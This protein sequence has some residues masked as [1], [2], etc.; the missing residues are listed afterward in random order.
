MMTRYSVSLARIADEL[1]M[2]VVASSGDLARREVTSS[3]LHRP[4]L[5]LTGYTSHF[6]PE[7]LQVI[8]W[9]ETAYLSELDPET[10]DERLERF[11]SLNVPG[12]VVTRGLHVM[13]D[14]VAAADRH[15]T[16]VLA[17]NRLTSETVALLNRFLVRELAPR[18]MVM[19][20]FVDVYGEGVLLLGHRGMARG[21]TALELV[22]RGHRLIAAQSVELRRLSD[23]EL[24]GIAPAGEGHLLELGGI[25]KI[26]V[27]ALYGLQAVKSEAPVSFV[28][29]LEPRVP[30]KEYE[31]LGMDDKRTSELGVSLSMLTIPVQPGRNLAVTIEVA[32]INHRQRAFGYN[33]AAELE[34]RMLGKAPLVG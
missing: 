3:E 4:G 6:A 1:G 9:T 29:Y 26:D 18:N 8:G 13:P 5:A 31:R 32:A 14:M 30:G 16:P 22:R 19:G 21:E 34:A 25:G 12:L 17:T 10:R 27:A 15:N 11:F 28:A 24:V 2:L 20:S 7:R 23:I 33:A